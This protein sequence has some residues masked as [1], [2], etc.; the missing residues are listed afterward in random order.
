MDRKPL[1]QPVVTPADPP[2]DEESGWYLDLLSQRI[3]EIHPPRR[4]SDAEHTDYLVRTSDR[5]L[6]LARRRVRDPHAAEDVVAEVITVGW[7]QR[8]RFEWTSQIADLD[9]YLGRVLS[10]KIADYFRGLAQSAQWIEVSLD[11]PKVAGEDDGETYGDHHADQTTGTEEQVEV[12]D[13]R[14][15][16][17]Q[18]F[19]RR[20]R[21]LLDDLTPKELQLIVMRHLDGLTPAQ[22]A[23]K[24]K[25]NPA[26]I[27]T[28]L[29]RAVSKV[30][31]VIVTLP[32]AELAELRELLGLSL[33]ALV[34]ES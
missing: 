18:Y 24:L 26:S 34:D 33:A 16:A 23:T 28:Q 11:A 17:L 10:N 7:K 19:D 30:R 25:G 29:S 9:R 32:P 6:P 13:T 31:A 22:I 5:M 3:L 27:R 1:G 15:R 14:A 4:L 2:Q 12:L 20:F 21:P 8:D